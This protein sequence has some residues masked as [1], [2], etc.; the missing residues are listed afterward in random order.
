MGGY[1]LFLSLFAIVFIGLFYYF[2]SE[3]IREI[4]QANHHQRAAQIVVC[5]AL[6][7]ISHNIADIADIAT[8]IASERGE[9]DSS[10][11]RTK[12]MG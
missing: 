4:K 8:T 12:N 2:A 10:E 7:H 6:T 1:I 11:R 3:Y 5:D 9:R